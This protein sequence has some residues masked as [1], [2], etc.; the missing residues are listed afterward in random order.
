MTPGSVVLSLITA[1]YTHL[2]VN[3][4]PQKLEKIDYD[5]NI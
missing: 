4:K 3:M 5:V 2:N 1:D